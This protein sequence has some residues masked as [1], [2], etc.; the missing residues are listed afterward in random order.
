MEN[1]L[2]LQFRVWG[3]ESKVNV[4]KASLLLGQRGRIISKCKASTVSLIEWGF[5]KIGV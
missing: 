3:L 5:P 2:K 4:H 1:K